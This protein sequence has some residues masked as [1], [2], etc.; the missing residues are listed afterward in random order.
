MDRVK[1]NGITLA[2]KVWPGHGGT[3]VAIHGLTANHACWYPLADVVSPGHRL[4]AY[5]L[6]GRGD[7]DKPASG[8]DLAVH[9]DDLLGLLDHFGVERAA[10]L[11]HSL[12]AGIAVRFAAHH[13]ERVDRLVLIDGG[14]D[15]RAEVFDSIAPAVNR[16]GVEFP[17]LDQFL[18]IMRGLPMFAGRW[19]A[20]LDRYFTTDVE[21]GPAGGVRSKAARHAI[22]EEVRNLVRT[23]LWTWHHRVEAPTLILRAPDGLLRADDCLLT[24]DE[25]DAL[26]H[27]IPRAR[28]VVVPGTNHYTVLLGDHP[29][30]R[31]ELSAFLST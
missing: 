24:E 13:P 19:N 12:G 23:R 4:V 16:L 25:A 18:T 21:P 8:Y 17:S 9:G 29:L 2:T 5:D 31:K 1:T 15:P 6:R 3:A 28:L 11:G 30:V 14:F 22:E 20:H 10:L 27:A 7:S 26:A